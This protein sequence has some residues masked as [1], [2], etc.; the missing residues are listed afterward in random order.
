MSG[1]DVQICHV[2]KLRVNFKH[3]NCSS[4]TYQASMRASLSRIVRELHVRLACGSR[5]VEAAG[6][7]STWAYRYSLIIRT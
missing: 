6:E 7:S 2:G 3:R 1:E 4:S 5:T